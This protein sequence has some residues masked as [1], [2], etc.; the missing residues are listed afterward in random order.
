MTLVKVEEEVEEVL[1]DFYMFDTMPSLPFDQFVGDSININ[2][3]MIMQSMDSI[4][5]A[6]GDEQIF[7]HNQK[8]V[9]L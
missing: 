1:N 8:K 4:H 2:G 7:K 9:F 6:P 5:S 3:S